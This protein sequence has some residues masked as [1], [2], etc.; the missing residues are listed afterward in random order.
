VDRWNKIAR[1][2]TK[3][4]GRTVPPVVSEPA[5]LQRSLEARNGSDLK[6]IF[7]ENQSNL[8]G[9]YMNSSCRPVRAINIFIG[10]EGGF[11]EREITMAEEKGYTALGLGER[12][13]RAETAAVASLALL[14]FRY[15]D[16]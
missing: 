14:Q 2:S 15:G 7:Y 6:I 13:L 16:I 4:C 3:Q 5:D 1:E 12:I 9:D 11:S 8:L 10:P